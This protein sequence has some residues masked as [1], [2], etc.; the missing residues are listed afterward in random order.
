MPLLPIL[1]GTLIALASAA[2]AVAQSSDPPQDG[3]VPAEVMPFVPRG[4]RPLDVESADL[5]GDGRKDYVLVAEVP[6]ARDKQD[7]GDRALLVL[8]RSGD[9]SLRLA[10][11]ADSAVFCRRCGGQFDP[12]DGIIAEPGRFTIHHYGGSGMRWA[13][14]FTFAWSPQRGTWTLARA[15][16]IDY[17]ASNPNAMEE[18]TKEPRHFGVIPIEKFDPETYMTSAPWAK[19]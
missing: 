19:H 13:R 10:A 16:E 2:P 5:D 12:F 1:L 15:V 7:D 11:R 17:H 14:H 8:L 4:Y 6:T 18:R 9:G 3:P